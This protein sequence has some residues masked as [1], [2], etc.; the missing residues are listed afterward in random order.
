VTRPTDRAQPSSLHKI[1]LKK[2]L[3]PFC[4]YGPTQID[5]LVKAGA[6]PKPI[7]LGERKVAWIEAELLEWQRQKIIERDRANGAAAARDNSATPKPMPPRWTPP[8]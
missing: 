8:S 1:L 5:A 6:F 7:R 3:G 4:G 2:H